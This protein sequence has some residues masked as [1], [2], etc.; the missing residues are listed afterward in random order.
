MNPSF[1][2]ICNSLGAFDDSW[3]E[4]FKEKLNNL[5]N[6]ARIKSSLKSL[7]EARNQFAHGGAPT[8]SFSALM[9]YFEDSLRVLEAIES[10]VSAE[11]EEIP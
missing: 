7:N 6:S 5:P 8:M 10:V 3:K 2:N 11:Q 9:I 4:N 1:S